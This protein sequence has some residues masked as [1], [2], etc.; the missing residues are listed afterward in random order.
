MVKPNAG[1]VKLN[2]DGCC[3]GSLGDLG[4]GGVFKDCDGNVVMLCAGNVE[5]GFAI[6]AEFKSLLEGM[7][8]IEELGCHKVEIEGDSE[9]VIGWLRNGEWVWRFHNELMYIKRV[10]LGREVSFRWVGR[11]ANCLADSLANKG[12]LLDLLYRGVHEPP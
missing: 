10:L 11:A 12:V 9:V 6:E 7:K 5:K 2:F 3:K 1:Y 8:I 4:V